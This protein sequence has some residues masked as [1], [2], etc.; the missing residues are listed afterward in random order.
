M[1]T[2]LSPSPRRGA[3]QLREMSDFISAR[4]SVRRSLQAPTLLIP[5]LFT[6]VRE[7]RPIILHGQEGIRTN[8]TFVTDAASAVC[9]SLE[10]KESHKI[11]VAG[12]EVLSMRQIGQSIGEVLGKVPVFK[13]QD[14]SKPRHLVGDI[15]KM[16]QILGPP[17]VKFREGISRCTD[18]RDHG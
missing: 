7:G 3:F 8:P 12:P 16:A 11:N 1:E 14:D 10:L 13:V 4:N 5:R 9:R 15:K 6:S 18:G 17:V 2:P